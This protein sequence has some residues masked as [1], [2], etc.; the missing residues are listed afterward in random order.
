MEDNTS[1]SQDSHHYPD[2]S[3]TT[4]VPNSVLIDSR[5]INNNNIHTISHTEHDDYLS[6]DLSH[7]HLLHTNSI[8]DPNLNH[9]N[10]TSVNNTIT[11]D[12]NDYHHGQILPF[13]TDIP[14]DRL[15]YVKRAKA[16]ITPSSNVPTYDPN[17]DI[18]FLCDLVPPSAINRQSIPPQ[19]NHTNNFFDTDWNGRISL[20][21]TITTSNLVD[22]TK[23]EHEQRNIL[24]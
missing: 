21:T 20:P 13:F 24:R 9:H 8:T 16:M 5:T 3:S 15:R 19:S 7:I 22:N 17:G 11:N 12:L 2:L 1:Q 23:Q 6:S 10:T 14:N 4:L 18:H